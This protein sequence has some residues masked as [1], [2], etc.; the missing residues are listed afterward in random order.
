MAEL[1]T[2]NDAYE[3]TTKFPTT[4]NG[5]E[6]F[7]IGVNISVDSSPHA[8]TMS[9]EV[10]LGNSYFGDGYP[11]EPQKSVPSFQHRVWDIECRGKASSTGG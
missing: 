3:L 10:A 1:F 11:P 8:A 7:L 9:L 6:V 2:I 5:K 4:I